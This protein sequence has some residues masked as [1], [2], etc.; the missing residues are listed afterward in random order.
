MRVLVIGGT[1]FIGL[2][3][4]EQLHAQGHEVVVFHRGLANPTDL[5]RVEQIL[6]DRETLGDHVAAFRRFAPDVVLDACASFASHARLLVDVF[7]GLAGRT[8]VLSSVDVYRAY[9][10]LHESEPG[11]LESLP[12]DE[13][14]PLRASLYPYHDTAS[15]PTDFGAR[16]DKIPIEKIVLGHPALPGTVLRLPFV[17]GPRDYQHRLGLYLRLMDDGRPAILLDTNMVRWRGTHGYVENV[18]AAIVR[19]VTDA[20]ATG[21]LYN[22]GEVDAPTERAWVEAIGRAAGW[23]GHVVVVERAALPL[24]LRWWGDAAMAQDLVTDTTR[25]RAELGLEDVVSFDE[26]LRRAVAWERAN[27]QEELDVGLLDYA[28]QDAVLAGL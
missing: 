23:T 18:A 6:G 27:R 25:M 11:P 13:A 17:Y 28:A 21:H 3:A 12:L 22:V 2:T 7:R 20:R 9:G 26:G 5:P 1:R 10:R 4:V 15:V 19:A 8:V 16:Y 24:A 14:A